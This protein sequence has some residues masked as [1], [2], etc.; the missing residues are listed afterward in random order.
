ME[1]KE[2]M[3]GNYVSYC[4]GGNFKVIGISEFGL[5]VENDIE[6]T[7]MEYDQFEPIKLTDEIIGTITPN[8]FGWFCE[9]SYILVKD[10]DFGYCLKVRNASNTKE[11]EFGYFKFLHQLQNVYYILSGKEL[12]CKL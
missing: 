5:D 12:K 10:E 2:L 7:Y 9:G 11:I 4:N 3:V 1:A 8:L 6:T